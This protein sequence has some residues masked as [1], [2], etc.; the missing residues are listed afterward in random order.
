MK[1]ENS[2]PKTAPLS[3]RILPRL[4]TISFSLVKDHTSF[5]LARL[6][7]IVHLLS[8]KSS[9]CFQVGESPAP[10]RSRFIH[11]VNTVLRGWTNYF[12]YGTLSPAYRVIHRHAVHRVRQWL[13]RKFEIQGRGYYQF[14]DQHLT[15]RLGLLNLTTLPRNPRTRTSASCPRAG[16]GDSA[17]PVR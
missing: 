1:T 12:C 4:P 13:G 6:L 15:D 17:R 3:A 5:S 8:G 10:A 2:T 9:C 16:C 11:Q 14:S 7:S